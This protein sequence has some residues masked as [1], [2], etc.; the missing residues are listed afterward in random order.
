MTPSEYRIA[1]GF[2]VP[3]QDA[4]KV[5]CGIEPSHRRTKPPRFPS[6]GCRSQRKTRGPYWNQIRFRPLPGMNGANGVATANCVLEQT[7]RISI[8]ALRPADFCW[9][10]HFPLGPPRPQ[11]GAPTRTMASFCCRLRRRPR[12]HTVHLSSA[13]SSDVPEMC[14]PGFVKT[15]GTPSFCL[16]FPLSLILSLSPSLSRSLCFSAANELRPGLGRGYS[17]A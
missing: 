11:L 3:F 7:G 2:R 16:S 1:H 17:S 15:G 10:G 5:S 4:V 12:P 9:R 13:R 6:A 14:W 8:S